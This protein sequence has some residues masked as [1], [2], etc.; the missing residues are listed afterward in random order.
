M[1]AELFVYTGN[2][3]AFFLNSQ[4]VSRGYALHDKKHSNNCP[5]RRGLVIAERVAKD[6]KLGV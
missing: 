6:K 1:V 3:N 5:S 2:K 4:M